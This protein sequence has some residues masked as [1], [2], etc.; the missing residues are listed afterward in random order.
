MLQQQPFG[1][2][3]GKAFP[4]SVFWLLVAGD[5]HWIRVA[6][7]AHNVRTSCARVVHRVAQFGSARRSAILSAR[8]AR[9]PQV[10]MWAGPVAARCGLNMEKD[11]TS[12]VTQ[13]RSKAQGKLMSWLESL[14]A[15]HA[16]F[17]FRLDLGCSSC[18]CIHN[19]RQQHY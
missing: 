6:R 8:T 13:M 9:H 17:R 2:A 19:W 15:V 18:K 3:A 14:D 10:G 7:T 5:G 1:R 16:W 11:Q 4:V 12:L